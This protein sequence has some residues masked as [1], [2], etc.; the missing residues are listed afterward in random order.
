MESVVRHGEGLFPGT[1]VLIAAIDRQTVN[2]AAV[3]PT[4]AAVVVANDAPLVI[5]NAL[6]L[7]PDTTSVYVV[8]GASGAGRLLAH[9]TRAA[10]SSPYVTG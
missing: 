4:T 6:A 1:P 8:I 10:S 7:L 2:A 9:R 3:P 5:E